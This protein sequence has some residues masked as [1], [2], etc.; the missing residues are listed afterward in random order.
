MCA[1]DGA[2]RARPE[3]RESHTVRARARGQI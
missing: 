1:Q 2:K 3:D